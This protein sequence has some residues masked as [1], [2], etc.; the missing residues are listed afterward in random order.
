[1][2]RPRGSP[3]NKK[4]TLN[5]VESRERWAIDLINAGTPSGL[6]ALFSVFP[7]LCLRIDFITILLG[8]FCQAD[9]SSIF[10][11]FLLVCTPIFQNRTKIEP[12]PPPDLPFLKGVFGFD[13]FSIF[14]V[15]YGWG[16]RS[17]EHHRRRPS[18]QK[19]NRT[20]IAATLRQP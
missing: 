19:I 8:P 20:M 5:A 15:S 6:R 7:F 16:W 10:V 13:F 14:R 11:R 2:L 17:R 1:M 4:R 3:K 12:K 18:Q 9:F